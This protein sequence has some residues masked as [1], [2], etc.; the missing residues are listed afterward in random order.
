M[1]SR[2]ASALLWLGSLGAAALAAQP[3]L[4]PPVAIPAIQAA[5]AAEPAPAAL[6]APE[7]DPAA[8]GASGLF[9]PRRVPSVAAP[10][11]P[12]VAA[13]APPPEPAPAPVAEGRWQL[14]GIVITADRRAA[15]LRP[16]S[17]AA[18]AVV[19]LGGQREGWTLT[20]LAPRRAV[21]ERGSRRVVLTLSE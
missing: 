5:P 4:L 10:P 2:A 21:L 14:L 18:V 19:P 15:L 17:G 9:D 1:T 3:W 20:D 12:P 11:P 8:L 7:I 16:P 6:P 13:P